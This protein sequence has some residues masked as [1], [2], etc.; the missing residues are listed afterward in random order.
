[1]ANDKIIAVVQARI[2]SSRFPAKVMKE[3]NGKKL[4]EIL[5]LRLSDSKKIDKIILAT[6]KNHENDTLA[7][8]IKSI[9]Y[10]VYRGSENDVLDEL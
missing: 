3:I 2:G 5:F 4:I 10:E 9:G 7:D 1:M 8:Y 6:S